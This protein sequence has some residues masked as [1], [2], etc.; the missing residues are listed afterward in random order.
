MK[1]HRLRGL[2]ALVHAPLVVEVDRVAVDVAPGVTALKHA[3]R[4]YQLAS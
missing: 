2:A 1:V 4:G 3:L